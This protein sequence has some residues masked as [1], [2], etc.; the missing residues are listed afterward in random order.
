MGSID[1]LLD[2]TFR[3]NLLFFDKN[4]KYVQIPFQTWDEADDYR[5]KLKLKNILL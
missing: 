1:T 4:D 3:W 2:L 5:K